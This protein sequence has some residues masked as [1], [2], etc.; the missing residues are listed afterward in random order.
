MRRR[1]NREGVVVPPFSQQLLDKLEEQNK[2]FLS[3]IDAVNFRAK[4]KQKISYQLLLNKLNSLENQNYLRQYESYQANYLNQLRTDMNR[5]IDYLNKK[6]AYPVAPF[7][8]TF[9]QINYISQPNYM[10]H[11]NTETDINRKMDFLNKKLTFPSTD[12]KQR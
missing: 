8:P 3:I 2:K 5:K 1:R 4:E 12:Q 6:V 7:V 9:P 10:S 11:L